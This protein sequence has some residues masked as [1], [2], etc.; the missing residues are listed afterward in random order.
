M[1]WRERTLWKNFGMPPE[2]LFQVM[3]S[4]ILRIAFNCSL[5]M[6]RTI[7]DL[8]SFLMAR[9]AVHII[10]SKRSRRFN[11]DYRLNITFFVT[12]EA[13]R[14]RVSQMEPQVHITEAERCVTMQAI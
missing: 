11:R 7:M 4:D 5:Q 13:F 9:A 14:Q 2:T 12:A 10:G 8:F 6:I 1:G 3:D